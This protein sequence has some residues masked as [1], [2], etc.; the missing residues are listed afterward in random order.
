[1]VAIIQQIHEAQPEVFPLRILISAWVAITY[2]YI[3]EVM[4]GT[5]RLLRMLPGEVRKNEYRRNALLPGFHGQPRRG[6]PTTWLTGRQTGYW[7]S[8][9]I[10]EYGGTDFKIGTEGR[11]TPTQQILACGR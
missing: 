2:R 7:E 10:P 1:M 5:R 9:A 6:F 8:I 3:S 11:H 4:G